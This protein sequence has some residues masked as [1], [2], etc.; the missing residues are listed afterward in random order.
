MDKAIRWGVGV[1]FF[2]VILTLTVP[3]SREINA[4]FEQAP[5]V[6]AAPYSLT[7]VVSGS[8]GGGGGAIEQVIETKAGTMTITV[9]AGGG[10]G[11]RT[12]GTGR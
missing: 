6:E 2:L 5:K 3:Q 4:Q 12:F 9:G 7:G 8:G 11:G 10:G 1:A